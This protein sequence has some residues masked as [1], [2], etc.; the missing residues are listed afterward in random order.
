MRSVQGGR[1][2]DW[3]A[4]V[5]SAVV[6][7]SVYL[8][9]L[10][11]V[12]DGNATGPF[13]VGPTRA[14][15]PSWPIPVRPAQT[16][17]GYDGQFY[18][19]LSF[20]PLLRTGLVG[21][22]DDPSYR[23][24]RILWPAIV[25][26]ASFGRAD[27]NPAL[28]AAFLLLA[29]TGG[30]LAVSK[31][32]TAHGASAGWAL[33]FATQLG[34]LV[35]TWR[36]LGDAILASLLLLALVMARARHPWARR[37]SWG[38]LSLAVLQKETGILALPA[39]LGAQLEERRWYLALSMLSSL[40]GPALWWAWVAERAPAG[41]FELAITFD[42]PGAGWL[43]AVA[44]AVHSPSSPLAL[45]KDLTLLG[46]HALM[47]G[48]G[49]WIGVRSIFRNRARL[50]AS[51]VELTILGYSLLAMML[52]SN[53]WVEAWAYARALLPLASLLLFY[54]LSAPEGRPGELRATARALAVAGAAAGIAFTIKNALFAVP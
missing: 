47:I 43:E 17:P 41:G 22:L 24:R 53:V 36:M 42:S 46:I 6:L 37:A 21:V 45:I 31:W 3:W 18:L 1:G 28:L 40:V 44:G 33:V 7:A 14:A 48:T 26:V 11:R 2:E 10:G 39:V 34:V 50:G 52:S 19:A 8:L 38:V 35:S 13:L 20:D 32:A 29:T 54:G 25:K 30:A 12:H 5:A 23:A 49:L 16:E 51:S 27:L 9:C 15:E 4:G